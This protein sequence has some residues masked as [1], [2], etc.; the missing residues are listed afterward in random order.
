MSRERKILTL[1]ILLMQTMV[2]T[3]CESEDQRLTRLATEYADRQPN[4]IIDS[5]RNPFSGQGI[6]AGVL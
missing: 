1:V 5:R 3:A 2:G 4:Q 6:G